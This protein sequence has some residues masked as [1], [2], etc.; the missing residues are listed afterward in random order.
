MSEQKVID[1]SVYLFT[2]D[3]FLSGE[4]FC[5]I[6]DPKFGYLK[7]HPQP[8]GDLER[9]Y[10]SDAYISHTDSARSVFERLYQFAK[11]L[12]ISYKFSR[13]SKPNKGI[14][15]LDF[16]CGTGDFLA[17]SKLKG[18]D[19]FG[20]EPNSKAR[21]IAKS[22]LGFERLKRKSLKD[23]E[24]GFDVIS[25]WHVLEHIP[26]LENFIP[27]LISKLNPEGELLIAVPNFKSYDAKVYGKFWAAYD[28]PRHLWHF[29]SE[30]ME[31]LFGEHNM[32]IVKIYPLWFDSF[33]I[34]LLSEKYRGK[35][36]GAVR[37]FFVAV[38]SNF[39]GIFTGNHS[40]LIYKIK[41]GK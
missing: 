38:I 20:I 12:N 18:M 24:E 41:K 28:V 37:A 8:E 2:R 14:R 33:Y 36:M 30:S 17:Y 34:S 11:R 15:L 23:F 26:D 6:K 21:A 7:T 35:K 19:V 29:S 1:P 22:K 40:S 39:V 13:I 16:G 10:D 5:L 25:L 9:Y 3:Y 32:H 31:K 27:E 4:E